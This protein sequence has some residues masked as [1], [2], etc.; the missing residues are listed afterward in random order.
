M[1]GTPKIIQ[2]MALTSWHH[3]YRIAEAEIW[4][5][6]PGLLPSVEMENDLP[7]QYH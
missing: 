6:S 7:A 1:E 3:K 4:N 2:F 5:T